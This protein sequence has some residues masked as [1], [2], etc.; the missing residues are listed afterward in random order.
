MI[1]R[2]LLFTAL[3]FCCADLVW[4]NTLPRTAALHAFIDPNTG[5][6]TT[7]SSPAIKT[8]RRIPTK[9]TASEPKEI[10][11]PVPGGGKMIRVK[12]FIDSH[13]YVKQQKNHWKIQCH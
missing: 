2:P 4:A 3:F 1:L 7:K 13:F 8:E 9:E 6:F 11:S 5:T 10:N 12:G